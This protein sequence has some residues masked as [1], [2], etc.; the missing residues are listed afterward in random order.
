MIAVLNIDAPAWSRE[1]VGPHPRSTPRILGL[2][3]SQASGC[4]KRVSGRDMDGSE[5][6]LQL[7]AAL[8]GDARAEA[9]MVQRLQP[10][11]H[12]TV[13]GLLWNLQGRMR[14]RP[15]RQELVDLVQDAWQVLLTKDG[16]ALL[17][18]DP[19]TGPL[20]PYVAK[21]VKNRLIS[22]LRTMKHS[23]FTEEPTGGET[24]ERLVGMGER[25]S[26][27]LEDADLATKVLLR[28]WE[29]LTPLGR[30]VLQ[31]FLMDG[32]TVED[33]MDRTGLTKEA[34]RSWRKRIR[35]AA[36]DVLQEFEPN[37]EPS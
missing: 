18:W 26:Q 3:V 10:V 12:R 28:V 21:I 13:A 35:Q 32:A 2:L 17:R 6:Q 36:R 15:A 7:R 5:E 9:W 27:R 19:V 33:V 30:E 23:P 24:L 16:E 37:K 8:A 31:V 29:V 1:R 25:F 14:G 20:D 4:A 34:V 11:L 22:K